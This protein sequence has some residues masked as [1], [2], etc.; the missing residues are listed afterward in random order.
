MGASGNQFRDPERSVKIGEA[1]AEL[2]RSVLA[3]GSNGLSL[4]QTQLLQLSGVEQD[5][6]AAPSYARTMNQIGS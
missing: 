3:E 2:S 4:L 1:R 6:H 5:D